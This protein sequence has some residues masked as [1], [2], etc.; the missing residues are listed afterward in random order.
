MTP[1]FSKLA[2]PG[3]GDGNGPHT[4]DPDDGRLGSSMPSP[5]ILTQGLVRE[6]RMGQGEVRALQGVD[7]R[8]APG[9][10]VALMGPSGCGKSTLLHLLGCLDRPTSGSYFLEGRDV[11]GLSPKE[12][13]VIRNTRIGFVFQN[14]FLLPGL[15]AVD[16]VA[17]PLLYQHAN[18]SSV[19][20]VDSAQAKARAAAALEQVG[21]GDREHHRPNE[22][23]G[24]ERQRV[25]IARG[26]VNQP[27][28]LLADEPTGALDSATGADLME[29]L[30]RLWR[31]GLSIL[32]VTHDAQVAGYAERV[33]TMK[34]GRIVR[35]S[36]VTGPAR[37][38]EGRHVLS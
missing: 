4:L 3:N 1:L 18:G 37:V 2:V 15:N 6:Y 30:V 24:G 20:P 27:A 34:D 26:L 28:I 33:I 13:A 9:E 16:N 19:A 31:E 22:L 23:S 11:S 32:L 14:F 8:I 12:R 36:T 7:L 35:D 10:F 38:E 25:A 29:L 21:L 17:L 5:I